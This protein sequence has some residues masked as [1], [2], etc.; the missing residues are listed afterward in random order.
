VIEK[1][2]ERERERRRDLLL[3]DFLRRT[4][5][6]EQRRA[7]FLRIYAPRFGT[8]RCA[9]VPRVRDGSPPRLVISKRTCPPPAD[10]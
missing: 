1:E 5:L 8:A 10:G 3:S 9:S 6:D 4:Y 2:R 7:V